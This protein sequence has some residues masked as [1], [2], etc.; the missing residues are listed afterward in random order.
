M[1]TRHTEQSALPGNLTYKNLQ[2]HG[3]TYFTYYN[4]IEQ[5]NEKCDEALY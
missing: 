5:E 3:I 2:S 4:N 1:A